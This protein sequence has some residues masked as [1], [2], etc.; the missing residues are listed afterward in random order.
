MERFNTSE[1]AC[2][3]GS[4]LERGVLEYGLV[5]TGEGKTCAMG[6]AKDGEE[7]LD[8]VPQRVYLQSL[9]HLIHHPTAEE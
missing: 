2:D 8:E 9:W 7:G 3:R 1:E 5:A 6:A 4:R